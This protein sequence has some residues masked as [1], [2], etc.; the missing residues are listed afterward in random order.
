MLKEW[1][2][3]TVMGEP[4][5][6]N[7]RIQETIPLSDGSA[8]RLSTKTYLTPIGVDICAAGGVVPDL[9]VYNSDTSADEQL[10]TAL[11]LLG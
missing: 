3:A 11:R 8:I 7:T 6:G 1:G 4:T 5:F 10:M 2:W 9:I